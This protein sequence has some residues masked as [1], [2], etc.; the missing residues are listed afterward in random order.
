MFRR[1]ST[2]YFNN[3]Q[4]EKGDMLAND[5]PGGDLESLLKGVTWANFAG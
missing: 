4:V 2:H 1:V 3:A 5:V